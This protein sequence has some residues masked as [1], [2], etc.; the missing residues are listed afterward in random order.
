MRTLLVVDDEPLL[1]WSLSEFLRDR[2]TVVTA[3]SVSE[4]K[5][6]LSRL[7]IDL[8]LTDF[9]LPDGTGEDVLEHAKS[10]R[11]DARVFF[12]TS[13]SNDTQFERLRRL[14]AADCMGKPCD[15]QTLRS[16][17]EVAV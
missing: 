3:A 6:A 4:A 16:R 8:I 2:F 15:L 14:G 17:L 7:T 12:L 5:D 9:E 10:H 11:P 1:R 13:H